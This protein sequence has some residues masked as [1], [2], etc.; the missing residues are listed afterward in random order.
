MRPRGAQ[1]RSHGEMWGSSYKFKHKSRNRLCA[2]CGATRAVEVIHR[3]A[4]D[5]FVY[6]V[7]VRLIV[8]Q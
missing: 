1:D 4:E 5:G 2:V 7:P 3:A 6:L 8:L